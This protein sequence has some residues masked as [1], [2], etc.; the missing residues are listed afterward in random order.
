MLSLSA[1]MRSFKANTPE[2]APHRPSPGTPCFRDT[3][4]TP[5]RRSWRAGGRPV[6]PT[7]TPRPHASTAVTGRSEGW[8]SARLTSLL[9]QNPAWTG[10]PLLVHW[11]PSGAEKPGTPR[12]AQRGGGTAG[13][14][15]PPESS[16]APGPREHVSP[17]RT[18]RRWQPAVKGTDLPGRVTSSH[19][20]GP[21]ATLPLRVLFHIPVLTDV[22][23][24]SAGSDGAP[25]P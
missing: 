13:G 23:S 22:V 14:R 6:C 11:G 4:K 19:R 25:G 18:W 12:L 20:A 5:G 21:G 2:C 3:D 10:L 8:A 15:S 1:R 24:T 9:G 16:P 17:E 7:E